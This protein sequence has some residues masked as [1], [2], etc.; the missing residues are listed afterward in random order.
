MN[1]L[2]RRFAFKK[3]FAAR[4]HGNANAERIKI[5]GN[6]SGARRRRLRAAHRD[7]S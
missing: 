1:D 5:V 4:H 7:V 2:L 6:R 3:I